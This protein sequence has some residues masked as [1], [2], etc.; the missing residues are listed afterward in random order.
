MRSFLYV[1]TMLSLV[2]LVSGCTEIGMD[3]SCVQNSHF[4]G[5]TGHVSNTT[6]ISGG[7]FLDYEGK[8]RG[9]EVVEVRAYVATFPDH[10]VFSIDGVAVGN[11][12]NGQWELRVQDDDAN[13]R[14]SAGFDA[15]FSSLVTATAPGCGGGAGLWTDS[16][17]YNGT[18][19]ADNGITTGLGDTT[20]NSGMGA[21]HVSGDNN[22]GFDKIALEDKIAILNSIDTSS[23]MVELDGM[24]WIQVN[25]SSLTMDGQTYNPEGVGLLVH[26]SFGAI[27]P[28]YTA[29]GFKPF[30][31]WVADRLQDS[32]NSGLEPNVTAVIN[33]NVSVSNVDA[34]AF[35]SNNDFVVS[36]L[37]QNVV[38]SLRNLAGS[39]I[40]GT[41]PTSRTG[42]R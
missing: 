11:K 40:I 1:F 41:N 20:G 36:D 23:D 6:T 38:D 18:W 21:G 12:Q 25:L 15:N 33:D 19:V 39:D 34:L 8:I 37:N 28:D 13:G 3:G 5:Q 30:V 42:R 27:K 2:V 32:L 14:T 17:Q 7:Q 24:T 10:S 31:S 29:P 9:S 16:V 22:S 4:S 26:D 35:L